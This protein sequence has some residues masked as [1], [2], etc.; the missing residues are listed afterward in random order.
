MKTKA[1]E[2]LRTPAEAHQWLRDNGI[3]AAQ[4]ARDLGIKRHS[5]VD[6]LSG[7]R[8]GLRGEAHIAAVALGIKADPKLK[9]AA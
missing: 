2:R 4:F 5:V 3:S 9:R 6:I 1:Q 8:R 7:R